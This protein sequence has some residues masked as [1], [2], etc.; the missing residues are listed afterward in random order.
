MTSKIAPAADPCWADRTY[1][2]ARL[3]GLITLYGLSHKD[4]MSL[5]GYSKDHCKHWMSGKH[6]V[7]PTAVLRALMY[8]LLSAHN[9]K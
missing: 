6:H 9:D 1:R 5:T 2:S 7:I 3:R 8:D 4:L